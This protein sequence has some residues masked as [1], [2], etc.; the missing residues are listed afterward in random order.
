[1]I[2]FLRT[3]TKNKAKKIKSDNNLI[4]PKEFRI[5]GTPILFSPT[6]QQVN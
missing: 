2:L 5:L 4:A 3:V 1:M 6:V